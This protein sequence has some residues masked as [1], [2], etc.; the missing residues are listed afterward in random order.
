MKIHFS[1]FRS[2]FGLFSSRICTYAMEPNILRCDTFGFLP[3]NFSLGVQAMNYRCGC[4]IH[5][6]NYSCY[7]FRPKVI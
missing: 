3:M 7:Y 2:N 1:A 4:L 6:I 5:D